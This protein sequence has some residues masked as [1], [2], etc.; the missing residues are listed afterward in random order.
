MGFDL[1]STAQT[2]NPIDRELGSVSYYE[3]EIEL[4]NSQHFGADSWFNLLKLAESYGWIPAGTLPGLWFYDPD[5][6]PGSLPEDWG[7]G[8]TSTS[9]QLVKAE[10]AISLVNALEKALD[11]NPDSDLASGLLA[12][13]TPEK[14]QEF[15]RAIQAS[16][17][18]FI[19]SREFFRSQENTRV[20]HFIAFCRKGAFY[21]F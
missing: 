3:K 15:L 6:F 7:D 1:I 14:A 9:G 4:L 18:P 16:N 2:E 8:Y 13:D 11:D 20:M 19:Q 5:N 21:I 17:T 10:D 12:M